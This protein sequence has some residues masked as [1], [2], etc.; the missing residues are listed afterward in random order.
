M[1]SRRPRRPTVMLLVLST[2]ILL[3]SIISIGGGISMLSDP[4]GASLGM[5]TAWLSNTPLPNYLLPGIWL[6]IVYGIGG[7][8]LL[9]ALWLRPRWAALASLTR[10]THEYWAW[11]MTLAF[12][13][14][15]ILRWVVAQALMIPTTATIQAVIFAIGLAIVI[16]PMLPVMRRYYAE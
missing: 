13:I 1:S 14:S 11:D 3:L 7:F 15:I 5:D 4:S 9:Y 10:W 6:T 8:L 16:I 12:G 2:C